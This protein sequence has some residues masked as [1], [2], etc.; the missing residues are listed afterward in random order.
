MRRFRFLLPL[1]VL[2]LALTAGCKR[3]PMYERSAGIYLRVAVDQSLDPAQEAFLD[4]DAR[5]Q[6]RDKVA[7]KMPELV[8]ACFY[9]AV[10]HEL[11]AEDFLPPTGGFVDVPAGAYDVLVYSLGTDA[12]QVSGTESRAGAYAFTSPTGARVKLQAPR[13]KDDADQDGESGASEQPVVF[14]PDHLFVGKIAGAMVPVRPEEAEK[15]VLSVNLSR[16]SESWTVEVVD[17]EGAERIRKAEIYI[18]G[19]AAGRYLWD[20]RSSNR[21]AALGFECDV[22]VTKGQLFSEFNTFGR[23]ADLETDVIVNVL[24]T[25]TAGSR[26]R[27]VYDVTDQWLNPD[28]TAH[29]IIID[30]LVEIPGDD[31]QGGGFTP[32][33]N[34]WDGE[35]IDIIIG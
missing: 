35:E 25:T 28:N 5:P 7:G 18:T 14:E 17:V 4:F 26:V 34:D 19:Q 13:T 8:R 33:V 3:I 15:T 29:R 21:P 11:V 30:E 16:L 27:Y 22:D 23:Y 32:I 6:L 24:V 12:T 31:F 10:S 2:L 1:C 20:A 9:D